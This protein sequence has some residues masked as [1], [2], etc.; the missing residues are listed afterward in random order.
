HGDR[1]VI[2]LEVRSCDGGKPQDAGV[3]D[4]DIRHAEVVAKLVLASEL[5]KKAIEIRVAGT[6]RG[7]VVAL[8][9]RSDLNHAAGCARSVWTSPSLSASG[10]PDRT[11]GSRQ[12]SRAR[13]HRPAILA[14][15]A[16][17]VAELAPRDGPSSRQSRG[18][19][20]RAA[21]WWCA[22]RAPRSAFLVP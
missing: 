13:Q 17:G 12:A 7:S 6:K 5:V 20:V 18:R 8:P 22:R 10:S 4:R 1:H 21:R 19:D 15:P 9:K 16:D 11:S 2:D 3:A 14:A